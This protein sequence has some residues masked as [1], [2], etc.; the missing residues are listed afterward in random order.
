VTKSVGI[1]FVG[2]VLVGGALAFAAGAHADDNCDPLMLS[3]TPQ[4]VPACEA[5]DIA[6]PPDQPPV[7]APVNDITDPAVPDAPPPVEPGPFAAEVAPAVPDAPPPVE[8]GPFGEVAPAAPLDA[9][10]PA[11]VQEPAPFVWPGSVPPD[12]SLPVDA[13]VG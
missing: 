8:P 6:P 2:A 1:S 11:D 9:Q 13:T 10:P 12:P 5:P 4:R 3:M 7:F